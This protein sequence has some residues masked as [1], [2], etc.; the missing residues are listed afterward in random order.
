MAFGQNEVKILVSADTGSAERKVGG[1][2]GKLKGLL[3]PAAIG[4]AAAIAGLGVA[5]ITMGLD[6]EKGMAEVFTLLPKLSEEGFQSLKND[7]LDLSK[8]MGLAT[9]DVVPA[10][11][12]AISAGVAPAEVL[13]FLETNARLVPS[14]DQRGDSSSP[15]MLVNRLKTSPFRSTTI[16]SRSP[17]SSET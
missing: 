5:G 16:I 7:V 2:S 11:Y 10:L 12:D 13:A 8:E 6:F 9:D 17:A 14:G 4:A 15:G 1:I 3:K